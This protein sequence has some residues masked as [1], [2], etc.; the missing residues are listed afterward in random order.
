MTSRISYAQNG[1]DVRI[2]HAFGGVLHTR[3][4][5]QL[6]Y[7]EV[8]ANEPRELSVTAALYDLGWRGLLIEADP[9]LARKLREQ[10]PGDT[11]VEVAAADQPGAITFY[12][13]AGTGLGTTDQ[14]EAQA[15]VDRG[16]IVTEIAVETQRL[17]EILDQYLPTW[18]G[19][20]QP[21]HVMSIDVEGAESSVLAG[22]AFTNHRPWV[23]CVEAV[24]PGTALASHSSWEPRLL[25]QGYQLAAFD[26]IN[27]WY[28]A[29]EYAD[30]PVAEGAGAPQ[31]T[32]ILE[33][34]ATPFNAID[35]G[36]HGWIT[37]PAARF[38]NREDRNEKRYAWQRELI[39]NDLKQQVPAREYERQIEEL[40]T[41]LINVEGSR[42]FKL[43][44][45][46]SRAGKRVV[47][48]TRRIRTW[49]PG[50]VHRALIRQRHLKH[51]TVNMGHLTNA[52]YLGRHEPVTVTWVNQGRPTLPP[53]LGLK[54]LDGAE[55]DAVRQWLE[56]SH[57][58]SDPELDGRM[59]NCDDEV[60]RVR[61]ALRT[62]LR[63]MD[64]PVNP[65]W[66]GGNRVAID[67]RS[68][69]SAAFGNR[70][71]G[72]F[73]KAVI[74]GAREALEDDRITL[75]IDRG[76]RPLPPEI[77]G[78]CEQ[79]TRI[80]EL[81]V[82]Q[83]SMLIQPSPMTHNADPLIP[84]LHSNAFSL[85]VVFDFI[86]MH[87]PSVYLNHAAARA[88][89]AANLD[90]LKCY[91]D[92]V[93]ISQVVRDELATMLGAP[94]SGPQALQ[95]VVAWPREVVE[96]VKER[97]NHTVNP[98][99]PIVLVTGDEPRKNTFGGL[100]GI[101]AA[102]SDE[103]QREVVVL[104]LAGHGTRVH[105]WSIA[106]AMRPGEARTLERIT[107]QEL[108]DLLQTASCV[109]VPSFDEGLSLPV[110]EAVSA[111]APLAVSNI[112]SH[113]ELIG[114][115]SFTFNPRRPRSIARA[116]G[117]TR[118]R[119]RVWSRQARKLNR[120]AHTTLEAVVA[121]RILDNVRP[122]VV[123]PPAAARAIESRLRVGVA[124]PWPPQRTG[125]ADFS[126]AVFTAL[127]THVDLTLY[128]TSGAHVMQDPGASTRITQRSVDEIF[129]NPSA[130]Q[131]AHDVLI[132]VV[133]NS[134]YHLPFVE[135][136]RH[137]DA[138]AIAHDTRMVEYYMALRGTGGAEH[139][140][141]SSADPD[142]HPSLA[143]P[144]DEQIDDMRLLQNA[145]LWEVANRATQV[146]MHSP[147]AAPTIS[148][149]TGVPVYLLPFAN[150]RVPRVAQITAEERKAARERLAFGE[151]PEE[152]IHLTSFGYVD[153]RTKMTD[154]VIESAAW[155]AQWDYPI[156]LHLVGS[157]T[158]Q[159]VTELSELARNAGLH[160]FN[161]TGFQDDETFRDWLMATDLGIQLRISPVLGVSGPLSD[162][163]AYGTPAVASSG[164]CIDVD[165]PDYIHQLP[166][167]V[168][169]IIVA[170]AIESYLVNPISETTR[171][172]QRREYLERKSP[173]RYAQLLMQLMKDRVS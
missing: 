15:A 98:Q 65:H 146:V 130:V 78:E 67:A 143:P 109:V 19:V 133:G 94:R 80:G 39:L 73:A 12:Q 71:I 11:V 48:Y 136:L 26:G 110:I 63:L 7:V 126:A 52:A 53:G 127:A 16:F 154:V 113:R 108:H 141:L 29:S 17:D 171:E 28:V 119:R 101:A 2:W 155:L 125:V 142:S 76:L 106:A 85:A 10:R 100:A 105:H 66:A 124:T 122:A 20:S 61:A 57:W 8:G 162:L 49:L 117:R 145:G 156:A 150:Q 102:T 114:R 140:M 9:D 152:T 22:I 42:S 45:V 14:R 38:Q 18:N 134:H 148:A 170:E 23:L 161:I 135:L 172:Q 169:P 118:G 59:D 138:I 47:A 167:A 99:G 81:D 111:G 90:A 88:E 27:R 68:L 44:R 62:R 151:Y 40:R 64:T 104:G 35:T 92:F 32:T 86:P 5:D 43:S 56:E 58:D 55:C 129:A 103:A 159:Q 83:F 120:H 107:D 51:V 121:K 50:P 112:G 34:I 163:A 123:A 132:T 153:Q 144:L 116:V 6:T 165:T 3:G 69:Q 13:V 157:A 1:E 30:L 97:T 137:V 82:A 91:S 25:R 36:A 131:Q 75:L 128:T 54:P 77:A 168:S 139:V 147:T 79:V 149:Q 41:A 24:Q 4:A 173:E 160:F 115:G 74:L 96:S 33:A 166:D 164:L 37:A 46:M 70:G 31:G 93:C 89:Y 84:L 95:A 158:D 60:G 72:R 21:I 87:Y